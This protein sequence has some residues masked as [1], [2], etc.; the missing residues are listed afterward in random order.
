VTD[1]PHSKGGVSYRIEQTVHGYERGHRLLVGSLA[2]DDASDLLLGSMSDLLTT[3]LLEG[4][5]SY[6][7]GYPL[8]SLN[9]YVLARTWAAHEV[10]RVGSVWTHSLV[11]DYQALAQIDDPS[12]LLRLFRRPRADSLS[13][14]ARPITFDDQSTPLRDNIP[15]DDSI[16][17]IRKLYSGTS[18]AIVALKP[19]TDGY[20]ETLALALWRQ[21]WPALRR[22]TAFFTF[23]DDVIPGID[24]K[25]IICFS[26]FRD[27]A[28]AEYSAGPDIE[29]LAADLPNKS[30]TQLRAFL[31]RHAFD[32]RFP[33]KSVRPL[34]H[35][36]RALAGGR[37]DIVL[38]A[39]AEALPYANPSRLLRTVLE[40]LFSSTGSLPLE[41]IIEQFGELSFPMGPGVVSSGEPW[42]VGG[43]L[44]R[45]LDTSS[46]F[47]AGSLGS[48]LFH[49]IAS[50]APTLEL[51]TGGYS[52]LTAKRLLG[53]RTN[54]FEERAFWT[55]HPVLHSEL[56]GIAA[57]NGMSLETVFERVVSH[58]TENTLLRLLDCWPDD[59]SKLL[60][61]ICRLPA[62]NRVLVPLLAHSPDLISHTLAGGGLND[63][64]L[65]EE[66]VR[67]SFS[68]KLIAYPP[69][70]V[71]R[72]IG[73]MD[74]FSALPNVAALAL[75]SVVNL[76][77][78]SARL[79]AR[80]ILP[81]VRQL[82][83]R[84]TASSGVLRYIDEARYAAGFYRWSRNEAL[85]DWT[86]ASFS[87]GGEV[88]EELILRLKQDDVSSILESVV[89]RKGMSAVRDLRDRTVRRVDAGGTTY[90]G[91]FDRFLNRRKSSW[92]W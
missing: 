16:E 2:L 77:T 4:D 47:A 50:S 17:A 90:Q 51:A 8:K 70:A 59:V 10:Q 76:D 44:G 83:L 3:G 9:S 75:Y 39:M 48:A 52:D 24:A 65:V 55:K 81:I 53:I 11:I 69:M 31:A 43:D 38:H 37:Q 58:L 68:E 21:M 45:L 61:M 35:L 33:R 86:V 85:D 6:L 19:Q 1:R 78:E 73:L 18:D 57:S 72:E 26:G 29:L 71:W 5:G 32:S 60:E 23:P 56:I 66:L 7:I 84:G 15:L 27:I 14:F 91:E 63:S 22:D 80:E 12:S 89:R 62:T 67:Y 30:Q 49:Q 88:S 28:S 41:H 36:W 64:G 74:Q 40:K 46:R 82:C 25:C 79:K 42:K 20:N 34:V 87:H 92:L 13:S 54:L